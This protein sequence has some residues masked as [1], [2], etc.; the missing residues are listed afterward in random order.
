MKYEEIVDLLFENRKSLNTATL[1][2]SEYLNI[3]EDDIYPIVNTYIKSGF[4]GLE[5]TVRTLMSLVPE[6]PPVWQNLT[7]IQKEMLNALR[8][9]QYV[10]YP[11]GY[12][13][14]VACI[15][16]AIECLREGIKPIIAV[17]SV[18]YKEDFYNMMGEALSKQVTVVLVD[19]V[20]VSARG[21]GAMLSII[22]D[23]VTPQKVEQIK[24]NCP[25]HHICGLYTECLP[26][27]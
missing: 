9:G 2:L 18:S 26:K 23:N 16:Y 24:Y 15:A 13:K 20:P 27:S 7:H 25:L 8:Q 14:T 21:S 5:K 1:V 22:C 3:R 6:D 4:Q 19:S 10:S 12:G 17:P 11:R